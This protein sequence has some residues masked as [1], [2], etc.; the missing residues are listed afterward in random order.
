MGRLTG[1]QDRDT[2]VIFGARRGMIRGENFRKIEGNLKSNL[3][4]GISWCYK[5]KNKN[6]NAPPRHTEVRR[7]GFARHSGLVGGGQKDSGGESGRNF[8]LQKTAR[9]SC[10]SYLFKKGKLVWWTEET[11]CYGGEP[12]EKDRLFQEKLAFTELCGC[13]M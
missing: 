1:R 11:K 2:I 9:A 6:E 10:N 12:E 4:S 5:R 8:Q 13:A 3:E 7:R